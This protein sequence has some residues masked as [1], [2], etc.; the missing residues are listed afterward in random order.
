MADVEKNAATE[1]LKHCFSYL[2]VA[3]QDPV[4]AASELY[5]VNLVSLPVVEKMSLLGLTRSEKNSQLLSA[6]H[7]QLATDPS[8]IERFIQVLNAKLNL[9]EIAERIEEKHQGELT[10]QDQGHFCIENGSSCQLTAHTRA[11]YM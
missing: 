9:Q 3:I 1:S 2:V 11:L 7:S 10:E 4:L 5:S 8:G 6:I